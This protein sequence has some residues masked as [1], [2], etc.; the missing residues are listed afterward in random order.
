MKTKK[1]T[2]TDGSINR[3]I[4]KKQRK[5]ARNMEYLLATGL[6]DFFTSVCQCVIFINLIYSMQRECT[7]P[8]S[9]RWPYFSY[10]IMWNS[11]SV[12]LFPRGP[13][14]SLTSFKMNVF[15]MYL[16]WI[17]WTIHIQIVFVVQYLYVEQIPA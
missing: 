2:Q 13:I 15:Y 6:G 1:K 8:A 11:V 16:G 17:L 9:S 10:F 4:S 7:T 3:V 5:H 14:F 12:C